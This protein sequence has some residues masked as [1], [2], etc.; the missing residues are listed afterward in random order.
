MHLLARALGGHVSGGFHIWLEWGSWPFWFFWE[1]GVLSQ[2]PDVL[3]LH[4]VGAG[5]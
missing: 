1:E 3:A 2:V 5:H 4:G